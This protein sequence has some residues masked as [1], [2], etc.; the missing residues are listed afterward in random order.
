MN[1]LGVL[2]SVGGY[3]RAAMGGTTLSKKEEAG[4]LITRI[5]R[6]HLGRQAAFA[7]AREIL[8]AAQAARQ[9]ATQEALISAMG[10]PDGQGQRDV[11]T[12]MQIITEIARVNIRFNFNA[13]RTEAFEPLLAEIFRRVEKRPFVRSDMRP[14]CDKAVKIL[15]GYFNSIAVGQ[16]FD[17]NL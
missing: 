2:S 9:L 16:R 5:A 17:S 7:R 14:I 3:M 10:G 1:F 11:P 15:K 13:E 12:L 8:E 6:G 4:A